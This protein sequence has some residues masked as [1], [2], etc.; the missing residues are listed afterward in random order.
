MLALPNLASSNA[1][2]RRNSG[3]LLEISGFRPTSLNDKREMAGGS[4]GSAVI[5]TQGHGVQPLGT[6]GGTFSVANDINNKSE[7]VGAS[8]NADGEM[9]AFYWTAKRGMVD[10]G[11]GIAYAISDAGDMVGT[12]PSG[13]F[14]SPPGPSEIWQ[15][16]LWRG[17]A[18]VQSPA[19]VAS[20]GRTQTLRAN[21]CFDDELNWQSK[22]RMFR[23]LAEL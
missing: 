17:T 9:R 4:Q 18:G 7:V 19:F 8:T 12:A 5:W 6:L 21:A 15:A 20:K 22:W 16:F 3:A 23:C 2:L 1:V 14:G 13:Q 11:P 10:L